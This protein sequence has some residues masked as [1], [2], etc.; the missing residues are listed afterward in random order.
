MQPFDSLGAWPDETPRLPGRWVAIVALV[1]LVFIGGLSVLCLGGGLGAA[2]LIA[3]HGLD[4]AAMTDQMTGDVMALSFFAGFGAFALLGLALA[5]GLGWKAK[6]ALAL[7]GP[8]LAGLLVAGV[9]GMTV[10]LLPG[11]IAEQLWEAFPDLANQGTLELIPRLLTDGTTVDR[12]AMVATIVIGAP[13]LE[14][15]CFRGVLWNAAERLA[16]GA[17]GQ[18]LAMAI[19]SAAFVVAHADLVQ[20]PALIFTSLFFGWLRLTTGSVW[21][22]VLAHFVNNGLATILSVLAIQYDW[23]SGGSPWWIAAGGALFT[24]G[25]ASVLWPWRRRPPATPEAA[26]AAYHQTHT[27]PGDWVDE[28]APTDPLGEV[29]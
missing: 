18:A 11:W 14:E 29:L 19:T 7:R 1:A 12:V 2:L 24:I 22:G 6:H 4:P 3:R 25:V 23:Q 15:V 17:A 26:W 27:N 8:T 28:D 21:P 20:S 5:V 10:G 13:L 9:G 16:P